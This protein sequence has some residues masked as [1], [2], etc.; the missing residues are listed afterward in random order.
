LSYAASKWVFE[1]DWSFAPQLNV[2]GVVATVILV[3]V[4]GAISTLDVLYQ[5]PLGILRGQ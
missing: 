5:K 3:T 1:I 2:L 4:V